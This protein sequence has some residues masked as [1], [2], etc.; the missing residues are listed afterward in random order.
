MIDTFWPPPFVAVL[1]L[2][3][4]TTRNTFRLSC[5]NLND[6]ECI[7]ADEFLEHQYHLDPD[8]FISKL[9]DQAGDIGW[10]LQ[11]LISK[12][13]PSLAKLITPPAE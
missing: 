6:L 1:M 10:T 5:R 8:L 3:S 9:V 7:T 2:S 13:V 12:H 4:A 11:Q